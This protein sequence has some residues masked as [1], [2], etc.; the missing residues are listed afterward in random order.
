MRDTGNSEPGVLYLVSDIQGYQQRCYLFDGSRV[1]KGACIETMR[2][3][4]AF[5]KIKNNSLRVIVV[6]AYEDIAVDSFRGIFEEFCAHIVESC[7]D[8]D[9]FRYNRCGEFSGRPR[10][11]SDC[12][13]RASPD[14][15]L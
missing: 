4:D 13:S 7:H 3:L 2:S 1:F 5:H 9:H 12:S 14:C 8:A 15:G 6:R 10:P 11:Y